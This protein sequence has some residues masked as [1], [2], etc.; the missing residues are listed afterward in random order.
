[1]SLLS[2]DVDVCGLHRV[3]WMPP[4]DMERV[5]RIAFTTLNEDSPTFNPAPSSVQCCSRWLSRSTTAL[6]PPPENLLLRFDSRADR[7]VVV[8]L[9]PIIHEGRRITLERSEKTTNRFVI[10]TPWL[11][12]YLLLTS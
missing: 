4:G 7:D 3:L 5:G 10:H 8:D 9:S 2:S 12:M 6:S 11:A 1:M